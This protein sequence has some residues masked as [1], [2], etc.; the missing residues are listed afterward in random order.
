[1]TPNEEPTKKQF[2]LKSP[3]TIDHL[4]RRLF[5]LKRNISTGK[6]PKFESDKKEKNYIESV[7]IDNNAVL[8]QPQKIEIC[9]PGLIKNEAGSPPSS[10]QE[11]IDSFK[12]L[13]LSNPEILNTIYRKL[14]NIRL[15]EIAENSEDKNENLLKITAVDS[16]A[17]M[18]IN[19]DPESGGSSRGALT[20]IQS[21]IPSRDEKQEISSTHNMQ[22][23]IM[24]LLELKEMDQSC[25]ENIAFNEKIELDKNN[26]NA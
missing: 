6:E 14:L 16:S 1:M 17:V 3:S 18:Y 23:L 4:K 12:V 5:I 2:N 10:R 22:K 8:I 9:K 25:E 24:K 7:S 19:N 20:P 15:K 11:P 13:D 21:K 26:K